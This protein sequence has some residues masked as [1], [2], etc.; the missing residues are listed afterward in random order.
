MLNINS[1]EA[2]IC[3]VEEKGYMFFKINVKSV[4]C[5]SILPP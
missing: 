1:K 4:G 2:H 5:L 3:E